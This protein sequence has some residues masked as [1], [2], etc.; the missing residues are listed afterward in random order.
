MAAESN[1]AEQDFQID[2]EGRRRRRTPA[3]QRET[4]TVETKRMDHRDYERSHLT[5]CGA[6]CLIL[7]LT[8]L[9]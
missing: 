9:S 5:T 7:C 1:L 8:E 3:R 2:A 4:V 6:L